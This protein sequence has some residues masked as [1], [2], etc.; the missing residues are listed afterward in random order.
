MSSNIHGSSAGAITWPPSRASETIIRHWR[1][2]SFAVSMATGAADRALHA[3]TRTAR[4]GH[5]LIAAPPE[6]RDKDRRVGRPLLSARK[7]RRLLRESNR[8]PTAG[9]PRGLARSARRETS[10]H[11]ARLV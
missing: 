5:A 4:S 2:A 8:A 7:S 1:H 9:L 3:T 11:P 6:A 10:S